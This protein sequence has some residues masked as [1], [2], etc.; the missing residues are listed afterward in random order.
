MGCD[1]DGAETNTTPLPAL[2]AAVNPAEVEMSSERRGLR[3][4]RGTMNPE[5][6]PS[7]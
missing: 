1:R 6:A 2:G 3:E 7:H 4:A 5:V